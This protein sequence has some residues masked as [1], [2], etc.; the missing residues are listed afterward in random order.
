MRDGLPLRAPIALVGYLATKPRR[1]R[2]QHA[3]GPAAAGHARAGFL[4]AAPATP[5]GQRLI[6]KDLQ[7]VGYATNSTVLWSYLPSTLDSLADLMSDTTDAASLTYEQRA[8]LVTAA[9]SA[10][11]DSY[12]SLAWGQKLADATSPD[13]AAAVIGGKPEGL[14]ESLQALARW[15]RRVATSPSEISPE[16]VQELRDAGF[17]D[18]QIFAITTFVALR[19]AFAMVN[20]ALGAR[21]DPELHQSVPEAVR[22][23][24]TF[25]RD[26]GRDEVVGPQS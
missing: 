15:A 6:E 20:D 4:E 3:Q 25:G 16:D 21:P 18:S 14:D 9:A 1:S 11:R 19:V 12:C 24:V 8:V 22:S 23:A 5:A 13:V 7:G 26:P 10:I 2:T 17:D